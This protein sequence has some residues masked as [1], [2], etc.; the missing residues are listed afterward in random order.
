M[1]GIQAHGP[2]LQKSGSEGKSGGE[3]ESR[4]Q[5]GQNRGNYEQFE[6]FKSGREFRIPRLD[7]LNR[8]SVLAKEI[9]ADAPEIEETD[10][11]KT[12]GKE[13]REVTVKIG[14]ERV[15]MQERITV[16]ALLDSGVTGL[17]MSSE[18]TKKQGFKLKKLERPM[19]VK[20]VDRSFNRKGP[21]ENTVEVNIYYKGYTERIEINVIRGQKWSVILEMPWLAHHNP[22]ID[23]KTGEVKMT[24]CPEECG[25]QWITETLEGNWTRTSDE[26]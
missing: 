19:Q 15:D 24:R 20:N 9:N 4:V 21:I 26:K 17:V 16:E 5:R 2:S 7:S 8:Y 6:Q 18:F 12:V 1:W 13:L 22:E 25:K 11:R 14:L 10:V 3:Q 23:W